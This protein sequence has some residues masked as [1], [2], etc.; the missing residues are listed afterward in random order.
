MKSAAFTNWKTLLY[1]KA[2][3]FPYCNIYLPLNRDVYDKFCIP[4]PS[5]WILGKTLTRAYSISGLMNC[6]CF[7]GMVDR[8]KAFSLISSWDHCQR[9]SP[10]QISD[11]LRAGFEPAQNLISGLVEWS[12]AVVITTTPRWQNSGLW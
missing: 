3:S 7:C 1:N 6:F 9:S 8:P 10:S 12:C 11:T 5:L 2:V 4:C